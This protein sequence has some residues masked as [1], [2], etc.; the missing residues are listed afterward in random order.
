MGWSRAGSQLLTPKRSQSQWYRFRLL[1]EYRFRQLGRLACEYLVDMYSRIEDERLQY[2]QEG[3]LRQAQQVYCDE[4]EAQDEELQRMF[5]STLP[6]SFIGSRAWA[7]EKV[8]D[9]LAICRQYG[10]PSIFLTMTTNPKWP[11]IVSR[12]LPGQTAADIPVDVCRVF[13][14][15]LAQL[16]QFLQRHFGTI[17][18]MISVIEFQLRGLPHAHMLIKV[19]SKGG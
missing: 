1:H 5:A 12:L 19:G 13:C 4:A 17:V 10:K 7:S 14:N 16:T 6:S 9:A 11:E 8:A 3:R 2:I 15:R 18:Y